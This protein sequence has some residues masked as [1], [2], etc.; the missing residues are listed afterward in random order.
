MVNHFILIYILKR[1]EKPSRNSICTC[2]V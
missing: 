2:Y 1:M